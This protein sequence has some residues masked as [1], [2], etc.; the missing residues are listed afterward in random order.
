LHARVAAV[1]EADF[2]DLIERQPELLA[3][4]LTGAGETERAVAQWLTAGQ[5]AAARLAPRE[6]IRHFDHGLALLGSLPEGAARDGQEAELQLARGLSLFTTEGFISGAA[7]RSYAQAR[8]F[9]ERRNDGRRLIVAIYGQWQGAYG[10]GDVAAASPLSS[11]LLA[12]TA[13]PATDSGLRLQAHHTAWTTSLI[14]GEPA[15]GREHCAAGRRLYDIEAHRSHRLLFG[16]HD[17]G[18]CARMVSGHIEWVVGFPDTALAAAREAT[19]LAEQL[20]HPLSLEVA[21]SYEAMLHLERHEPELAL[22]QLAAIELM[23]A[24][25]RLA[26]IH[27]PEMLRGG[28]LLLQGELRD[29]L[30]VLRAGLET[31]PGRGVSR[32]YGLVCLA[33]ATASSGEPAAA[34][35]LIDEAIAMME[36]VGHHQYEPEFYRIKGIALREQNDVAGSQAAFAEALRSARRRQMKAYELRAATDLARLWGEEGRREAARELLAP[37]YGWFTQGFDTADL[38]EAKALLGELA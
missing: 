6:A 26:F 4:H 30:A 34:L 8:E 2:S 28:A 23:V 13:A 19:E 11:K 29:A 24:E 37:V 17:P 20:H 33:Q 9:A 38:R 15:P 31:P 27:S 14:G 18:V 16:G 10:G 5:F 25:Q 7:A 35:R 1:L 3:H 22:Q 36:A 32:P 12:L 21:M